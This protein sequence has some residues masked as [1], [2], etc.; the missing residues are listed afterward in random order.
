[1]NAKN[2]IV[3]FM[4]ISLALITGVILHSTNERSKSLLAEEKIFL[5]FRKNAGPIMRGFEYS[6][7]NEGKKSLSIRA[8]KFSVKKK[9]IRQ[10]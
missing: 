7:Y 2:V 10:N 4:L 8:A 5:R 6:D 3:T 9:K 1:M